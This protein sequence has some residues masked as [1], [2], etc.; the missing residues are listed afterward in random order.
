[1][2]NLFELQLCPEDLHLFS[3]GASVSWD[4][5]SDPLAS[6]AID[7]VAAGPDHI[8]SIVRVPPT[9]QMSGVD[10]EPEVPAAKSYLC[11]LLLS[12]T[13]PPSGS[14]LLWHPHYS[15]SYCC[16]TYTSGKRTRREVE[17]DQ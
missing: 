8:V 11:S 5:E 3:P 10:K 16:W 15:R 6:V 13:H 7:E 12:R 4:M 1:M 9:P 2:T 14:V 17:Q